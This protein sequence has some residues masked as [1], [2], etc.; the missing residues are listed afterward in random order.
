MRNFNLGK[1]FLITQLAYNVDRDL[2]VF[3][4][5]EGHL[6]CGFLVS[7]VMVVVRKDVKR[8]VFDWVYGVGTVCQLFVADEAGVR[9][10]KVDED[11]KTI[12]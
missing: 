1:Q 2:V 9:L 6:C 3:L 5:A 8:A 12:K 7:K 4:T 10:Y 11:K